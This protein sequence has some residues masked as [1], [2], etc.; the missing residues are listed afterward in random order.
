MGGKKSF[1]FWIW[2]DRNNLCISVCER[3]RFAWYKGLFS[4][5]SHHQGN[6]L[7]KEH[8]CLYG[9]KHW[10]NKLILKNGYFLWAGEKQ[11]E[12]GVITTNFPIDVQVSIMC[13]IMKNLNICLQCINFYLGISCV[14]YCIIL[15]VSWYT[16]F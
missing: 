5:G 16:E 11:R 3:E 13:L 8:Y 14:H 7:N 4:P 1:T 10:S 12:T 15:F 9:E 6:P 2:W